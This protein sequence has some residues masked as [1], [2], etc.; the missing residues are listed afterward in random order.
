MKGV[1][2]GGSMIR[3]SILEYAEAVKRRYL[4]T[5]RKEKSRTLS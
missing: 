2:Q 3:G 4:M 1:P 5:D